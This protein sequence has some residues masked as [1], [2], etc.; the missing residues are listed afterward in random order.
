LPI[1]LPASSDLRDEV[2]RE[3]ACDVVKRLCRIGGELAEGRRRPSGKRSRS[4]WRPHVYAPKA[5]PDFPR[6]DAERCF[7]ARLSAAWCYVVRQA[8]P[9]TVRHRIARESGPFVRFVR[10]CLDLVGATYADAVELIN[11]V[12]RD[13]FYE[14]MLGKCSMTACQAS[15]PDGHD[16]PP[17]I[18]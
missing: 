3:R 8:P 16:A 14:A 7:V 15:T 10:K 12:R 2:L 17:K 18:T 4:A 9:R 11:A 1:E 13:P 6:R 5:R